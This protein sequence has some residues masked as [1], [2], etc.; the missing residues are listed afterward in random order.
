MKKH[1]QLFLTFSMMLFAFGVY[2]QPGDPCN[3]FGFVEDLDSEEI[4]VN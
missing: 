2:A 4:L 3:Q 1:L